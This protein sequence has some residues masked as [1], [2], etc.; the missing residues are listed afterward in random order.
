MSG[1]ATS[2]AG[3]GQGGR[4]RSLG[5][6]LVIYAALAVFLVWILLPVWYLLVSSLITPVS[7]P[8]QDTK[9]SERHLLT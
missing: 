6:T 2:S 3:H 1:P 5:M 8:L 7:K 9:E 4:K